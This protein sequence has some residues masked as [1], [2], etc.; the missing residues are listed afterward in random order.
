[1]ENLHSPSIVTGWDQ[2]MK[3]Y[4]EAHRTGQLLKLV[5]HTSNVC[6]LSCPG[7]FVNRPGDHITEKSKARSKNEMN[8]DEQVQLLEEAKKMGV[9]TVDIVGAGEPTLD[10]HFSDLINK[11]EELEMKAV[12]FTHGATRFFQK[13][14]LVKYKD[15][16]ISFFI[17]LWSLNQDR[18]NHYVRGSLQN[19]AQSRD[20]AIANLRELGFMN[21]D[22]VEI[23]S[24][25]RKTTRVGADI[26]VMKSNIEETPDIFRF[27]RRNNIMPLIKTYIPQGP[28]KLD[29]ESG[30]FEALSETEKQQ[31]KSDAVFPE[32]FAKLRKELERI[33]KEEFG[34]TNLSVFYP[35]AV[36]CTQS[37]GSIYVTINGDILSC[38]GTSTKYDR[39]V[40]DTESLRR[41]IKERTEIVGLGCAPRIQ[42]AERLGKHIPYEERN[43]LELEKQE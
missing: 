6:N 5:T 19:Y 12:V 30:V 7:C 37:A 4:I 8:F 16:P 38:V 14:N 15:K 22:N 41:A 43:I 1:M 18:M 26:L 3:A 40:P 33:D 32:E 17:K 11:V 27:C 9:K 2:S 10:N 21:G 13:D 34:N 29:H 24:I 42:E 28:T 23:D 25:Q 39:Y 36:F 31:L 35:Q 20:E